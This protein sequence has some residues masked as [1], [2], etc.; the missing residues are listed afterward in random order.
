LSLLATTTPTA[1][2][3]LTRGTGAVALVLLTLGIVLGVMGPLGAGGG[4]WP[5]FVVAGLHRNVTLLAIAFVGVHVVTTIADG[6]API[7][8]KD[9]VIPFLSPYR[10]LWLGLGAVAFDLLLALVVT[11]MLRRRIGLRMWSAVHWLAYASWPVAMLHA[12]GTGTDA[13]LGW[14]A[15]LAAVC[16]AAVAGSILWRVRGSAASAAP[17]AVAVGATLL[18]VVLGVVW[19]RS[20]PLQ[21]GWARRAGTP[22]TLLGGGATQVVGRPAAT[23]VSVTTLP[24]APFSAPLV[25]RFAHSA[26]DSHGIESVAVS[27]VTRGAV[28]SRLRIDLWGTPLAGGG[29]AMRE[30]TVRFGPARSPSAYTGKIVG[31]DGSH[32]TVSLH[33]ASGRSLSLELH[34]QIDHASGHVDGTLQALAGGSPGGLQG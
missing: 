19:Y 30:S 29:V 9:A 12:L 20:G 4:R 32:V 17:R 6:F 33:D 14:M 23:P 10:P 22:A 8:I 11:S 2:W 28:A 27:A 18:A 13:R 15:A 31:L 25:G 21:H 1:Y 34:L 5:R 7:G 26:P 3:Y 16:A 24:A